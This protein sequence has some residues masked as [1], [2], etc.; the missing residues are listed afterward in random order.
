VYIYFYYFPLKFSYSFFLLFCVVILYLQNKK[1][2]I[3]KL[4]ITI[5]LSM[6]IFLIILRKNIK[7]IPIF[8]V[9][10]VTIPP[11][12]AIVILILVTKCS[13]YFHIIYK[14]YYFSCTIFYNVILI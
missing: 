9:I 14:G 6:L 13:M 8:G 7:G 4:E 12:L 1:K 3:N 11:L 2:L 5:L 10:L